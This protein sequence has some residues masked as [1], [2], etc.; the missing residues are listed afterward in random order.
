[1]V[2][3]RMSEVKSGSR[4]VD[5]QGKGRRMKFPHLGKLQ[6]ELSWEGTL[7]IHIPVGNVQ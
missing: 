4:D 2:Y 5:L 6:V 3:Y 7:T 1:M